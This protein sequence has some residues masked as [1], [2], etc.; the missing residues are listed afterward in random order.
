MDAYDS[1]MVEQAKKQEE[2]LNNQ[3]KRFELEME[4][5]VNYYENQLAEM[6]KQWKNEVNSI[7]THYESL[8]S[9]LKRNHADEVARL[10]KMH[11]DEIARLKQEHADEIAELKRRHANEIRRLILKYNPVF[12]SGELAVIL[13][14]TIDPSIISA[15]NL[16]TYKAILSEE[17]I[18]S[19]EEFT[20]LRNRME[21]S[22]AIMNAL[23]EIPYENS[24]PSALRHLEYRN[25]QVV[26]E[27]ERIWQSMSDVI[28]EKN[29]II[30]DK[31]TQISN[32]QFALESLVQ[33]SRENGYILDPRDGENIIVFMDTIH[34]VRENDIGYVFREDDEVIGTVRFFFVSGRLRARLI[35]LMEEEN[36]IQ[37]FDKILIQ[38]Q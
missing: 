30:A 23:Q 8:V 11:A 38:V 22:D 32:F 6:E 14:T 16:G 35:E 28:E 7:T 4:E 13:A 9:Q 24:I 26:L 31:T 1:K 3:Q 10:K 36:P 34:K 21:D 17:Q 2:V 27:Y 33:S 37:P 20:V 5:T 12:D 25:W 15:G 19:E 18:I 29:A